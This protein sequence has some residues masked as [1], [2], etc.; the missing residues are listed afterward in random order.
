MKRL[1]SILIL[2]LSINFLHSLIAE[3]VAQN[4]LIFSNNNIPYEVATTIHDIC[5]ERT[6]LNSFVIYVN[7]SANNLTLTSAF[8]VVNNKVVDSYRASE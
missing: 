6:G 4:Y 5:S 3:Q 8:K 1:L 7:Y 2:L